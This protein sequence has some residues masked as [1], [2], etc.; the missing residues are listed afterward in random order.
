M[1]TDHNM[2]QVQC[3]HIYLSKYQDLLDFTSSADRQM[4]VGS[5]MNFILEVYRQMYYPVFIHF[6]DLQ[7]K[8][9]AAPEV[10]KVC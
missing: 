4:E 3:L 2:M 7:E 9:W 6:K 8:N 10:T 5:M 1:I